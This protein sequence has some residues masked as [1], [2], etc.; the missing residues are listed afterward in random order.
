MLSEDIDE[1]EEAEKCPRII[2]SF[3]WL[4]FIRI[5]STTSRRCLASIARTCAADN[6]PLEIKKIYD[7]IIFSGNS[8]A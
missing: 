2:W 8:K 7:F 1:Y 4:N 6:M 3:T 5:L